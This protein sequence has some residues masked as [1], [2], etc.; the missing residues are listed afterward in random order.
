MVGGHAANGSDMTLFGFQVSNDI[1]ERHLR[2]IAKQR[3]PNVRKNTQ[4]I[5]GNVIVSSPK[6][7]KS[8]LLYP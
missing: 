6:V 8:S 2:F 1:L 3:T 5:T 7:V 4:K